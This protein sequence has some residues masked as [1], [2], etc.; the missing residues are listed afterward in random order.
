M[1]VDVAGERRNFRI[2]EI[3]GLGARDLEALSADPDIYAGFEVGVREDD[4]TVTLNTGTADVSFLDIPVL[5]GDETPL[6]GYVAATQTPWPGTI[7]VYSSPEN[8]G[9]G[10]RTLV[11]AP[12]IMGTLI[13]D[14]EQ[15]VVG[16]FDRATKVT[17]SVSS[18]E[19][20]SVTRLQLFAGQNAAAVQTPDGAWEVFQ[21][22]TA[23]LISPGTYQLSGLLRGQGGTEGAMQMPLAAGAQFVLLN[24][25][26]G[27]CGFDAG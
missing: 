26:V 17:V 11:T 8:S 9:F 27:A 4:T 6:A 19:L 22:E 10:L 23:A 7:A 24:E 3:S 15:G 20:T 13:S 1:S 18:G 21:F 14:M 5:R 2:R 12:A 25:Q 16:V